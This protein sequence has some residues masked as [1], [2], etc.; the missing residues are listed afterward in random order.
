[1]KRRTLLRLLGAAASAPL[2]EACFGSPTPSAAPS[3]ASASAGTGVGPGAASVSGALA[4][5]SAVGDEATDA[6]IAAFRKA[7]AGVRIDVLSVAAASELQ[8]RIRVEKAARKADLFVG[9]DSSLHDVLAREGLLEKYS[10]RSAAAPAPEAVDPSGSWTGWYL[11]LLAGAVNAPRLGAAYARPSWD[12]LTG[13]AWQRKLALPDPSKTSAGYA[14]LAV[15]DFRGGRD[16]ARTMDYMKRIDPNVTEYTGSE[17]RTLD[18]VAGGEA[19]YGIAWSHDILQRKATDAALDIVVPEDTTVGVGALSI[20]SGTANPRA[21]RAF[22]DWSLGKDAA[23]L[24]V[25]TA[26]VFPVR[27]DVAAPP[28]A[29]ALDRAKLVAYDRA[30]AESEHDRLV[31]AWV[32]ALHR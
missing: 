14:L 18:L 24:M 32:A 2:A 16:D 27:R 4:L 26:H 19:L 6:L 31:R 22:V 28:G 11:T 8:T 5:Y 29:P 10:S 30:W 25:R 9:G 7:Y 21:A 20:V 23:E 12:D 17:L 1:M 13:P 3:S 15:Q